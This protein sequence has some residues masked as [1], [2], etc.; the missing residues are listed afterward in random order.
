MGKRQIPA[1]VVCTVSEAL[2]SP[3]TKARDLV[4]TVPHT[5]EGTLRIVGSPLKLSNSPV[6]EPSAPPLLGEHTEVILRSLLG[7]NDTRI[8]QLH[9]AGVIEGP[10]LRSQDHTKSGSGPR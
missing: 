3:N 1:G 8:G 2:A 7:L 10:N 5:V 6:R 9:D 4:K